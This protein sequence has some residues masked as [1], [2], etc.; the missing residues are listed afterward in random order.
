[1]SQGN[2]NNPNSFTNLLG[3]WGN[4]YAGSSSNPNPNSDN[5]NL[6]GMSSQ[7]LYQ[8]HEAL[9]FWQES[10]QQN[11]L[12]TNFQNLQFTQQSQQSQTE[13]NEVPETPTSP[14]K[15][16]KT[17][18][19]RKSKKSKEPVDDDEEVEP[20]VSRWQANEEKLL[21][22]CWVAASEDEQVGRS[23]SKDTFWQRVINE[24][25]KHSYHRRG[26]D[27]IQSK[28]RTL[29]RDCTKFNAIYKRAD[30]DKKK[31]GK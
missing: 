31:W 29:N 17:R 4:P 21:A 1:M 19:K 28:W 3:G 24:F 6:F 25:N 10:Q 5:P 12:N 13:T 11:T 7:E 16:T 22:T 15:K 20:V 23:Q 9:R 8:Q 30:R 18:V 14:P 2:N 26:K 27:M